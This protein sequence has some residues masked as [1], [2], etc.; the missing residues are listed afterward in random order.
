MCKCPRCFP[1]CRPLIGD[2]CC[3]PLLPLRSRLPQ[4]LKRLRSS[5]LK[6]CEYD[7]PGGGYDPRHQTAR[8][9]DSSG[10]SLCIHYRAKKI[11]RVSPPR[12]IHVL[13]VL[14]GDYPSSVEI[15]RTHACVT[16]AR[17]RNART[18]S[19]THTHTHAH[20][21]THARTHTNTRPARLCL[22]IYNEKRSCRGLHNNYRVVTSRITEFKC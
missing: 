11:S 1:S 21:R 4:S 15:T 7:L 14:K 8:L 2:K 16:H 18:H 19:H 6:E 3:R 9:G 12:V 13:F 5:K 20:V 10:S 22:I 17:V